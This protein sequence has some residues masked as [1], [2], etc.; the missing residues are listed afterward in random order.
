[1]QPGQVAVWV[2]TRADSSGVERSQD[3][4]GNQF[5]DVVVH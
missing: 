1:M 4:G 2:S 5:V 3:V